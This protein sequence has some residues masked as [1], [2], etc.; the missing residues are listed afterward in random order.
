V[1]KDQFLQILITQLKYQNPLEPLKPDEFLSQ[2][3]QLTEVE[4]LTN[5]AKNTEELN[6]SAGNGDIA[7]WLSAVGKKVNVEGNALS[8]GDDIILKPQADFD[9]IILTFKDLGTGALKESRI[10]KGESLTYT[11]QEEGNVGVG[12]TA[13]KGGKIVSCGAELYRVVQGIQSGESGVQVVLGDGT[14]QS[15]TAITKIRQ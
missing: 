13:L 1:T 15:V 6:K 7:D 5:I 12:I 10:K 14:T 4:Q 3:S 11:Y 9:E 2:L 8:K